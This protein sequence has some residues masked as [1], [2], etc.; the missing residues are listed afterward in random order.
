MPWVRLDD[1]IDENPK[2]ASLDDHAF[3]LFVC[4]LAYCNRNL[5]D[6]FIPNQVGLGG[7][8][9]CDGN[10]T[11]AIRQLEESGMWIE[12]VGGWKV[13]DYHKYQPRR[14]AVLRERR[15]TAK[16]VAAYR[17]RNASR[18]AVTNGDTTPTTRTRSRSLRNTKVL[19]TTA[20]PSETPKGPPPEFVEA[21]HLLAGRKAMKSL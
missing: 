3:A 16:R 11:P 1:H 15:E 5:T 14:S 10:T 9:F 4:G 18:N 17:T 13:H 7:L 6:G 20:A 2:I 8:R 21:V 12:V 19:S